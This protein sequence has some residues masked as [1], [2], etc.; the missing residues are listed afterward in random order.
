MGDWPPWLVWALKRRHF[1]EEVEAS[2]DRKGG[3]LPCRLIR[4]EAP[5]AVSEVALSVRV[6]LAPQQWLPVGKSWIKV[7]NAGEFAEGDKLLDREGTEV[8]VCEVTSD[9]IRLGRLVSRCE[10]ASLERTWV[11]CI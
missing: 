6:K 11:E 3:S 2:C 10:A 9:A 4:E 5:P 1:Q 7:F 8:Q